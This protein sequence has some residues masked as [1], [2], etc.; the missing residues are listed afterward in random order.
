MFQST[1]TFTIEIKKLATVR[2]IIKSSDKTGGSGAKFI[3]RWVSKEL[4]KTPLIEAIMIST[5]SGQGVS[6]VS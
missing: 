3:V 1:H 2:F 6:F 4:V 5:Q